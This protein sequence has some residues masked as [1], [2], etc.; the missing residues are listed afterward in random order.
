MVKILYYDASAGIS[1]D[2]NLA[3]LVELGVDFG[4]LCAEL[5]KLNLNGEF[6]LERKNVLKNGIAATK[7]DV[8]PLK[9]QPHARSYAGIRQILE[10]S[11][12]SRNCKQRAGAIFRTIAQAEAKVHGTDVERVHFHEIGAID[13]IADIAGAA[14][15]LEYLFENLGVLRV[16]SSKIE[17]GGGVAICDH[18]ALSVP[19]PAVCEILKGVPVS[20]GRANFEMTTPTGAAILKAC[21]DEFTDGASF[22]IEKIG[23]GAGGKD[24]A[25]FANVLRAM[26]C[27]ADE[28]LNDESGKPNLIEKAGYGEACKQIL[29]STNIDDMDAESFAFACEILRE[30]GAL[31]VFSRSI[32]MKKGR[33]GFE[34]NAL[35]RKQDAQN[36][37]DLIFTHT[38]AIGVREIE[39]AKTELKR[40]FVRV[41]TKFGEIGLKISG[42]CQTQK[43]KPEFEDCKAAA[44]AHGTTIERV[45]KEAL[46]IYDETRKTKG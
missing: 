2:M 5:E 27:E 33:M 13:S 30:N 4:Y 11:N 23:Y 18:G 44:L 32:F 20:L 9:S 7:I 37:K 43:A 24:A 8:V 26:I 28:N 21:A 3:A 14:I 45:R 22:K 36:L 12:L 25:G 42:T 39:V 16:V 46:K 10:S 6:K 1:G 38:T 40:E 31:D 34:L 19:A 15:C 29:I 41:Q 17:L 35:C